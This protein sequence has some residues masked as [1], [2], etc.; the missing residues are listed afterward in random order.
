MRVLLFLVF[1]SIGCT[2]V[3]A[4]NYQLH[5]VYIYSFI[6]YVEWPATSQGDFIVG[7]YGDSPV[8]DH[9]L[10]MAAVKKAGDRNIK[11]QKISAMESIADLEMLFVSNKQSDEFDTIKEQ[12]AGS[13]TLI[14]TESN[15]LGEE[16]SN[17]NFVEMSGKLKFELNRA[18]M[19]RQN[20]KVS[21]ELTALAIVI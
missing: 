10:K 14:I 15:G 4:Q 2:K 8:Y 18:A 21:S 17:I 16:G 13:S 7:V 3:S 6:K 1:L 11:I 12:L 19:E 5:S 9:L 20:L